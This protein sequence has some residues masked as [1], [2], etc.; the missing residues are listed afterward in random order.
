MDCSPKQLHWIMVF[1]CKFMLQEGVFLQEKPTPEFLG[2]STPGVNFQVSKSLVQVDYF[3]VAVTGSYQSLPTSR[4]PLHPVWQT[5][6]A[7]LPLLIAVS[8]ITSLP[9]GRLVLSRWRGGR[10]RVGEPRD[11]RNS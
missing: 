1:C 3:W 6:V 10:Y 2:N 7:R 8:G 4:V 9:C 5:P 11:L